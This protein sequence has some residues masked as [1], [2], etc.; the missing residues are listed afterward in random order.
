MTDP[1]AAWA[2]VVVEEPDVAV[3]LFFDL[4]VTHSGNGALRVDIT[5]SNIV[6]TNDYLNYI[7]LIDRQPVDPAKSYRVQGWVRS[8]L[9]NWLGSAG[10]R[11]YNAAG[12][13][14]GNVTLI[15]IADQPP[16]T[17]VFVQGDFAPPGTAVSVAL[18]ANIVTN[19]GP[20]LL[21]TVW[22]DQIAL[23][24]PA[25]QPLIVIPN[26]AFDSDVAGW[27]F[28]NA[29]AP[30][31]LTGAMTWEPVQGK[32]A[33]GS[34][35]LNITGGTAAGGLAWLRAVSTMRSPV[36][37]GH[38]YIVTGWARSASS[39]LDPSLGL[40]LYD[41]AGVSLGQYGATILGTLAVNTWTSYRK[42]V[43]IPADVPA[44]T[45]A[46]FAL[47]QRTANGATG[48]VW[49]DDLTLLDP[50]PV[51]P[52]ATIPPGTLPPDIPVPP[53]TY[54][55]VFPPRWPVPAEGSP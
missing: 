41:A 42:T 19:Q 35:A 17:W 47:A 34:L 28:V 5:T 1:A 16:D 6:S 2:K 14:V 54:L 55:S 36:A 49:F 22:F 50:E 37:P 9:N 8:H 11:W 10:M 24:D 45:A 33:P 15:K 20:K 46:P 25:L 27:T 23:I 38:T 31:L 51:P 29:Y 40:E 3:S 18:T 26:G 48:I 30:T 52:A 7:E 13:Q 4:A 32:G 21:D 53:G 39:G 43:T 44:V 12:V